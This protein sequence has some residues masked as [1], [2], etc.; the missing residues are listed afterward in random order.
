[1]NPWLWSLTGFI[2][3]SLP[4]SLWIGRLAL[5]TDLRT[6]GDGN[7]G[8]ANVW[9]AGGRGWAV[10]AIL[11]DGFKGA[12]PVGLA[13]YVQGVRGWMLVPLALAPILGHVYSPWLHFHGGKG[14]A[15][16]FGVWLGLTLWLGPTI[17]GLS[18]F[19]WRKLLHSDRSVTVA[20]T[21]TLLV[22]LLLIKQDVILSSICL[23]NAALLSWTYRVMQ[24]LG[25]N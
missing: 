15:T 11:L 14:L 6:I 21:L 18:L 25:D 4:F 20:G 9:Q 5:G 22:I 3:G 7:P 13:Y 23:L 1:M 17:L 10:V 2:S 24:D 12:I 8:G 19:A 16:S